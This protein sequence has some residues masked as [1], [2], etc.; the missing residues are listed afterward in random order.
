MKEPLSVFKQ[1]I[2][3]EIANEIQ[4]ITSE[5]MES[6]SQERI[7]IPE[8]DKDE[9]VILGELND[10]QKRCFTLVHKLQSSHEEV[11]TEAK[12]Q[13]NNHEVQLEHRKF[14]NKL[15]IVRELFEI[16]LF[17]SFPQ[18]SGQRAPFAIT[19]GFQV[20]ERKYEIGIEI[21]V[22]GID[23]GIDILGNIMNGPIGEA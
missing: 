23:P 6:C 22:M 2:I 3:E 19:R 20:V 16:S 12:D 21:H 4:A 13:P 18:F 8:E 15:E 14:H 5:E 1:T 11:C 7:E 10:Y 9:V 17:E